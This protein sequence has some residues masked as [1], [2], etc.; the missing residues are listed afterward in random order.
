MNQGTQLLTVKFWCGKFCISL[1]HCNEECCSKMLL[2]VIS[3]QQIPH[4]SNFLRKGI[5][6]NGG[7]P[8]PPIDDMI[9]QSIS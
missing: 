5:E 4:Q 2:T 1:N 3:T 7:R 6:K 8:H 9:F